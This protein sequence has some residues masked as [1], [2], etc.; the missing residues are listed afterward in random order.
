MSEEGPERKVCLI[1]RSKIKTNFVVPH[2]ALCRWEY[3]RWEAGLSLG[4]PIK[5]STYLLNGEGLG[6]VIRFI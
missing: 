6:E 1:L 3:A 4:S 2:H 5:R